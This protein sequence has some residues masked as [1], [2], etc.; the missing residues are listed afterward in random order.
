MNMLEKSESLAEMFGI[1]LGDGRIRW[2]PTGRHYQLDI[3]LNWVDEKDYVLYVKDL[4]MKIFQS[5]PK[6][7]RQINEDGSVGKGIYLTIYSKKIVEELISLGLIPGKKVE[8]QVK[9]P[10]WIKECKPFILACL[11]GLFDTDGS[12]FPVMKENVFRLNFKNGSLPLVEDFKEMTELF[13][14]KASKISSYSENSEKTGESST[15]YIVQIQARNQV[16]RFLDIINPMK[17]EY[18]KEYLLNLIRDP[19]DYSMEYYSDC[20]IENWILLYEK[21]KSFRL[22]KEY[23]KNV[24]EKTVR[25]DTIRLRIKKYFGEKYDE[26]LKDMKKK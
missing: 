3:I 26:W 5:H 17:W 22:V 1:I 4:L 16:K 18:R 11:K 21:F 13:E 24:Q 12:I 15:T 20:E 23:L 7:S 25:I 10:K 19:F 8:N 6:V 14:I 9:V 2:D